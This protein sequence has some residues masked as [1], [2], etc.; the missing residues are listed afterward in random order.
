MIKIDEIKVKIDDT[1]EDRITISV[2]E[3]QPDSIEVEVKPVPSQLISLDIRRTLDNNYII[4]DHP[5]FDIVVNPDKKKVM[6][7]VKKFAKAEAYPH[8][9]AF[10]DYLKKR[11]VILSDTVKGGNIFGSIEAT[12]PANKKMDVVKVVLLNIFTFLRQELPNLRKALDYS[13]EV[14]NSFVN[15]SVEDSTEYGEVPQQKKKGTMD[16]FYTQYYGLIYR[17]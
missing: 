16:P 2:V 4:H 1:E 6:T 5:L 15:P 13:F 7:F 12:Y 17:L 11:G 14:D 8:Q 3:P 9:D 10:F